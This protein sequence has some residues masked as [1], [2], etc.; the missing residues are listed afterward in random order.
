KNLVKKQ[1]KKKPL[2]SFGDPSQTQESRCTH[3]PGREGA[4][5]SSPALWDPGSS[6]DKQVPRVSVPAALQQL[7]A[8]GHRKAGGC[9]IRWHK[10]APRRTLLFPLKQ[11]SVKECAGSE[12]ASGMKY[13]A[14]ASPPFSFSRCSSGSGLQNAI[15][16]A[17]HPFLRLESSPMD[18]V[19]F[20][21]AAL[22][23]IGSI[24]G[25]KRRGG[26]PSL[27]A[28]LS[29]GVLAGYGA[30]RVSND[31]RDVKVSFY[32]FLPGHHN[33]C[34]IQE[35]QENNA[36][37]AGCRL[38]PRDDPETGPAIVVAPRGAKTQPPVIPLYLAE[39]LLPH[40]KDLFKEVV[41]F[42]H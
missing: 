7:S 24:L 35:I 25:Y 15:S 23:T 28:G 12:T 32:S 1:N 16:Y 31:K 3:R 14:C 17:S 5:D 13:C 9:G 11:Y 20:G 42:L 10:A 2:S 39:Q 36:C 26:V 22:V 21:Y 19:G 41:N 40:L 33:G 8:S 18:L 6:G 29:V 37:W 27:I 4:A 34:E 30:Y 38:K